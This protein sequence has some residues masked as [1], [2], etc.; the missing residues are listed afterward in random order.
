MPAAGPRVKLDD[1]TVDVLATGQG[2]QLRTH[3]T[4]WREVSTLSAVR[5]LLGA[6]GVE[7]AASLRDYQAVADAAAR[8]QLG[9]PRLR[10]GPPPGAPA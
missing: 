5:H 1:E 8:R 6:L 4:K 3:P 7:T 2:R 9:P 10:P